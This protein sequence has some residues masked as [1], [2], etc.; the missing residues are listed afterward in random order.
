MSVEVGGNT[1]FCL[2]EVAD[3]IGVSRQTLWRW[4]QQGKVPLGVRRRDRQ[5]L[6]NAEDIRRI[7]EYA[8]HL[9]PA[10]VTV[11]SDLNPKAI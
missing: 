1:Y 4:R 2:G 10:H 6:F 8:N 5:V 11:R 7:D 3:Q 9:E